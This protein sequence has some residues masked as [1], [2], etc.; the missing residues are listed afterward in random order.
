MQ[1]CFRKITESKPLSLSTVIKFTHILM[2]TSIMPIA[3]MCHLI[4]HLVILTSRPLQMCSGGS[5]AYCTSPLLLR[6]LGLN[7]SSAIGQLGIYKNDYLGVGGRGIVNC[8]GS[9]ACTGSNC[10][11]HSFKV[12]SG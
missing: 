9:S 7:L 10:L 11:V 4:C 2:R 12:G 6:N 1:H 5:V 3:E 8:D